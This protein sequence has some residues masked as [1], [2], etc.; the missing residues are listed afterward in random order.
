MKKGRVRKFGRYAAAGL[1]YLAGILSFAFGT[2]LSMGVI[3][4][5]LG[6]LLLWQGR[7][8]EK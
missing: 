8:D 4:L 1:L 3:W 2:D 7:C 5:A 6:S